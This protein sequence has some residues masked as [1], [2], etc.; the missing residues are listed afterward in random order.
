VY[1]A[2]TENDRVL[3]L[4]AFGVFQRSYGFFGTGAGFFRKPSAVV[5]ESG[6]R[7]MVLDAGNGR[8]QRFTEEVDYLS[9]FGAPGSGDGQ[10]QEAQALVSDH[11]L[12]FAADTGNNRVAVFTAQGQWVRA[13]TAPVMSRPSGLAVD[14]EGGLYVADTGNNRILKYKINVHRQDAEDAK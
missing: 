8:V 2:D 5:A 12:V 3:R 11:G 10:L 7:F 14:G 13:I 1:V 4:D 6:G 9:A